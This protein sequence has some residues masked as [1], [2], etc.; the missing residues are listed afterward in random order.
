MP[1][2]A[3]A[4][5]LRACLDAILPRLCSNAKLIQ[6]EPQDHVP[7]SRGAGY[8]QAGEMRKEKEEDEKGRRAMGYLQFTA[9]V[10]Q[11]IIR[12]IYK[13][14]WVISL[15]RSLIELSGSANLVSA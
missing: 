11:R 4:T 8:C 9:Q 10:Y 6:D 13:L 3:R 7:L 5:H 15:D 12:A 2:G 1:A 14:A